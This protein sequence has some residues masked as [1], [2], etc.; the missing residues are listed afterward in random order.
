ME[1]G[2]TSTEGGAEAGAEIGTES[3]TD[4]ES[5]SDEEIEN[6]PGLGNSGNGGP[7][8]NFFRTLLN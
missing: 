4:Q 1:N 8:G 7:V 5:D 2:D 6:G 3:E